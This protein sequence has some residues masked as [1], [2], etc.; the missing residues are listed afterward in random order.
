[1]N[2]EQDSFGIG[3][4]AVN[5]ATSQC[6]GN[7]EDDFMPEL[8]IAELQSSF[9]G[10]T[11]LHLSRPLVFLIVCFLF[12]YFLNFYSIRLLAEIFLLVSFVADFFSLLHFTTF[13]LLVHRNIYSFTFTNN[14]MTFNL[15]KKITWI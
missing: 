8:G 12:F 7:C 14:R 13:S 11:L 6:G 15:S 1:M 4:C 2:N 10:Y 3:M 5:V 9:T